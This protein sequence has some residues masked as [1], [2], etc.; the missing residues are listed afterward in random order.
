MKRN[1]LWL[2]LGVVDAAEMLRTNIQAAGGRILMVEDRETSAR[3]MG[4]P[5]PGVVPA[6]YGTVR[7]A[8]GVEP[9]TTDATGITAAASAAVPAGAAH[10]AAVA[11]RHDLDVG[12][13]WRFGRRPIHPA[14]LVVPPR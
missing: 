7:V 4:D 8:P 10:L 1:R 13:V 14:N 12:N 9:V 3:R 6:S 2:A 5:G 11:G